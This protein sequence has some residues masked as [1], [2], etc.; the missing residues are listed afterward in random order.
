MYYSV[1][2]VLCEKAIEKG[3]DEANLKG[4]LLS[5]N[6]TRDEIKFLEDNSIIPNDRE[7]VN[8]VLNYLSISYLELS[9]L[10]GIIP[11]AYEKS[12]YSNIH[13]I[14]RNLTKIEKEETEEIKPSFFKNDYG[15]LYNANCMEVMPKLE[16]NS[17]DMIFADP[18]FNLKKDYGTSIKD[19]MSV[20][21]YINWSIR[22][23]DE[24]IR[25]LKPGG[26]LYIY[27]IPKWCIHYADYLNK[28]MIFKSWIA[29]DMKNS[30]PIKSR[31]TPSH[32]GLL[33]YV[34]EGSNYTF[35]KQRLPIQT[36]RHCGG[37]LK[38]YGGYK[39]KMNISGVNIAD[40]WYDIYP[41]R[42][43]KNRKYNELSLT[44]LDRVISFST[45]EGDIILDPFGGSGTTYAVA[46]IL[47]RR[48]IGIE[49]G[50]CETIQNRLINDSKDIEKMKKI[51]SEK[52]VIFTPSSLK[53]RKKNGFWL[54][55]GEEK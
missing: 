53:L 18:P 35:N 33:Y 17:V 42:T 27:N 37:E 2:D 45:N 10:M 41:V 11:K 44:L 9:L 28:K 19:D 21:E 36:C 14:A 31:Y 8:K 54:P 1:Y 12:F 24:C 43:S 47:N 4:E 55:K 3:I 13:E 7:L 29:I 32:Y 6:F 25:I 49:I 50:D 5:N 23:I 46:Q 51:T 38:D 48:W 22:W 52:N 34:K 15:E 16:S 30:F 39:N 26:S 20:S 40:V